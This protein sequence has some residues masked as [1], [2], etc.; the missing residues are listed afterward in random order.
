MKNLRSFLLISI[1]SLGQVLSIHAARPEEDSAQKAAVT[2]SRLT[3]QPPSQIANTVATTHTA[4]VKQGEH[5]PEEQTRPQQPIAQQPTLRDQAKNLHQRGLISAK[6]LDIFNKI[7]NGDY[8]KLVLDTINSNFQIPMDEFKTRCCDLPGIDE[9][10]IGRVMECARRAAPKTWKASYTTKED[11]GAVIM[12][13]SLTLSVPSLVPPSLIPKIAY[14]DFNCVLREA[15]KGTLPIFYVRYFFRY[16]PILGSQESIS[17]DQYFQNFRNNLL[18]EN[19]ITEQ[20][21]LLSGTDNTTLQQVKLR[22]DIPLV[23]Y[24]GR[25]C[26]IIPLPMMPTMLQQGPIAAAHPVDRNPL[27]LTGQIPEVETL[28]N[29]VITTPIPINELVRVSTA[30][31]LAQE[32][33]ASVETPMVA[34]TTTVSNKRRANDTATSIEPMQETFTAKKV[35]GATQAE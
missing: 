34:T 2:S 22:K 32:I 28:G 33:L 9:N 11:K 6:G 20:Q 21:F 13:L 31:R 4:T 10:I 1:F 24:N 30:V 16:T 12:F 35:R 15:K 18:Y 3:T 5:N 23:R 19:L 17:N 25:D 27:A 8:R 7:R 14:R 26:R 29:P